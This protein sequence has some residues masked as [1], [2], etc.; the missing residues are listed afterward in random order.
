MKCR[1]V[2][3]CALATFLSLVTSSEAFGQARLRWLRTTVDS[4]YSDGNIPTSTDSHV[5]FVGLEISSSRR[6]SREFV[7]LVIPPS[8]RDE[9][10]VCLRVASRNGVFTYEAEYALD[11]HGGKVR[12]FVD[13]NHRRVLNQFELDAVTVLAELKSGGCSSQQ[14]GI[15]VASSWEPEPSADS[16]SMFG[17]FASPPIIFDESANSQVLA[18]CT[19]LT[20]SNHKYGYQCALPRFPLDVPHSFIITRCGAH[21]CEASRVRVLLW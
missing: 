2:V 17:S 15:V 3:P 18:S 11:H 1:I 5:A 10:Y 14:P 12:A 9:R 21:K 4:Y 19:P 7:W 16:I 6:V 13:S 8:P 20:G